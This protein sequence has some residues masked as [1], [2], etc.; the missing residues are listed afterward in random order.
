[1]LLERIRQWAVVAPERRAH[2]SEGRELTYG[3]L[4]RAAD[5]L[6]AYLARELPEDGS[7]I[8]VRGHKEPEM[9]IAFLGAVGAGH[10]YIPLDTAIPAARVERILE[11]ARA[12]LVLTP[13]GI[14]ESL[15]RENR[16][17]EK[18]EMRTK[19]S[20]GAPDYSAGE[21]RERKT[22]T[23]EAARRGLAGE[24][25][26][27][28]IFTSGSTGEPKG[29]VITL[30][31]LESFVDWMMGEQGFGEGEVFLNQAPFSFDL[32]VMDLYCSLVSGG[33][34]F[35]LT[36]GQVGSARRLFEALRGS[37]VTT[38]VSTP[39]FAQLCLAERTF[40]AGMLPKVRRFLFCGETLAPAVAG[41]LLERFPMARVWNTYGPT[42][43]T[44]ATTSVEITREVLARYASLPVGYAKPD[45]EI[46][47]FDENDEVVESGSGEIVI[48]GPNVSV[49]YLHQPELTR[50]AFFSY[51][52]K[53]A[54][55][56]GDAGF[57]EDGLLFFQGRLDF[58]IKLH[59]YRIELGDVEANLCALAGVRDAVVL[60]ILREGRPDAL[61][62]FVILEDGMGGST[63]GVELRLR[64]Q[65]AER[66]PAYMVP[67]KFYFLEVFPLTA[68]GKADRREL[69]AR[70][71]ADRSG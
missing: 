44:V 71:P 29:V 33:T 50:R 70:L 49:G 42:E 39:S 38:W 3:E 16:E 52:G 17:R 32:S 41:Q 69:A 64:Q 57:F 7:P 47:L 23:K 31:C 24:E 61:A 22:V 11:T 62:A 54:Y 55:R 9:L 43:A 67:G 14:R 63:F 6:A 8:A 30:G 66:V 60:P 37:N 18:R 36:Q 5:A 19:T 56:T 25:P 34:L 51:G 58:Q 2:V 35:S 27:Y 40:D 1:M 59:G 13:E 15:E 20:K 48:A 68:N 53:R 26:F 12:S 4:V 10:P 65:L 21:S 46:V 45:T 28:I